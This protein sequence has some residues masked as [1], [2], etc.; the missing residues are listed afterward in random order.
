MDFS[1]LARFFGWKWYSFARLADRF[2]ARQFLPF[3][4]QQLGRVAASRFWFVD[5]D[6]C[7]LCLLSRVL[8][9][10]GLVGAF[11]A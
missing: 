5:T 4:F 7:V 11:V 9:R 10:A 2:A 8:G 1:S 3:W 6:D